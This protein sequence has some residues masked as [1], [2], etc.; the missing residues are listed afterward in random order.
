MGSHIN[1]KSR[2]NPL[3]KML[4]SSNSMEYWTACVSVCEISEMRNPTPSEVNSRTTT[5]RA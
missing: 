5:A 3:K 4:A 2:K 1:R